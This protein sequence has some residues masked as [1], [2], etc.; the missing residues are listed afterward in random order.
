VVRKGSWDWIL[1]L[2]EKSLLRP[3]RIANKFAQRMQGFGEAGGP[4]GIVPNIVTCS[5]PW[6]QPGEIR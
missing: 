5:S 4:R 3:G 2:V 1:D 6:G